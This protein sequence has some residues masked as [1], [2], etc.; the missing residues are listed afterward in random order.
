MFAVLDAACL[1]WHAREFVNAADANRPFDY[2]DRQPGDMHPHVVGLLE[3]F[4]RARERF[5]VESSA[6]LYE[7]AVKR[8]P[9]SAFP[10][11][12][13]GSMCDDSWKRHFPKLPYDHKL[14]DR[15]RCIRALD[16]MWGTLPAY[17]CGGGTSNTGAWMPLSVSHHTK[18]LNEYGLYDAEFK[19]PSNPWCVHGDAG[20]GNVFKH[21]YHSP[22]PMRS[23]KET[24]FNEWKVQACRYQPPRWPAGSAGDPG[25]VGE[26]YPF[27][28][29]GGTPVE[30]DFALHRV[31]R[32]SSECEKRSAV[33]VR[34]RFGACGP[35]PIGPHQFSDYGL[36]QDLFMYEYRPFADLTADQRA[37]PPCDAVYISNFLAF[38][39]TYAILAL[40]SAHQ[41]MDDI[42]K[43]KMT[44]NLY[45]L[46]VDTCECTGAT[47]DDEGAPVVICFQQ[48]KE[49]SQNDDRPIM[50]YACSLRCING[51]M[52]KYVGDKARAEHPTVAILEKEYE[53]F[54]ETV[55]LYMTL[56]REK[57]TEQ[58][59]DLNF[60]RAQAKRR[61]NYSRSTFDKELIKLLEHYIYFLHILLLSIIIQCGGAEFIK[62]MPLALLEQRNVEVPL[63]EENGLTT[64]QDFLYAS[65][66]VVSD[67]IRRNNL[68]GGGITGQQIEMIKLMPLQH[69]ILATLMFKSSTEV[70][71]FQ[72]IK[73]Q[74]QKIVVGNNAQ[75]WTTYINHWF[76]GY[77]QRKRFETNGSGIASFAQFMISNDAT[78]EMMRKYKDP[79][80]ETNKLPDQAASFPGM[81]TNRP[82]ELSQKYQAMSKLHAVPA[83]ANSVFAGAPVSSTNSRGTGLTD[84]VV[85]KVQKESKL[86]GQSPHDILRAMQKK[87]RGIAPGVFAEAARILDHS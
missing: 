80:G 48:R 79:V 4:Y 16:Y 2:K 65:D 69:Q 68:G 78:A 23:Y 1:L 40:S 6:D 46:F 41:T 56:L 52:A 81:K 86:R 82:S 72:E 5:R 14:R 39:R 60:A 13:I 73:K 67:Q 49:T 43:L 33:L 31:E 85:A 77:I 10:S 59:H 17:S 66:D 44:R 55:L 36:L 45:R 9:S 28:M 34:N 57:A 24:L 15:L 7:V 30:A 76:E 63:R 70:V 37:M 87:Y 29:Y 84:K 20:I 35:L 75:V 51:K 3:A 53:C 32:P 61:H 62:H 11:S 8:K 12:L 47:P 26:Y 25:V 22:Y 58:Q 64:A 38:A 18:L 27:S 42:V 71:D 54:K 74:M 19:V 50:F 83:D 21:S